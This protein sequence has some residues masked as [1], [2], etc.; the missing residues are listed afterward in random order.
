LKTFN[1]FLTVVDKIER[2]QKGDLFKP[3]K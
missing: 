3:Q 2:S 1:D